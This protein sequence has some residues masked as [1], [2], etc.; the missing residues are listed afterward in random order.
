MPM[1]ML[2][3]LL[4]GGT[5]IPPV[6][7]P[8]AFPDY[9]VL[10]SNLAVAGQPSA[11]SVGRLKKM[12]FRTVVDL[13]SDERGANEEYAALKSQGLQ[14]AWVPVRAELLHA[15]D[16]LAVGQIISNRERGPFLVH[17]STVDHVGAVWAILAGKAG[18]SPEEALEEGRKAGL[19]SAELLDAV[20]G[21]FDDVRPE[22]LT[23]L[24]C[25]DENPRM[26][27]N[28]RPEY[29][30]AAFE[31]KVE[32][33][34]ELE[35]LI[36]ATGRVVQTDVKKSIPQLDQAAIHCV[37]KWQFSPARRK[38]RPVAVNASAPIVFRIPDK[39]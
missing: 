37:S 2:F 21:I 39:R 20:R 13:R 36:D 1:V 14:Y 5:E 19:A 38:G 6:M 31:E 27:R 15:H 32:G 10:R 34:V 7:D 33:T 18:R 25:A 35:I 22:P 3:A 24:D 16:A 11:E 29:P 23:C 30:V 8:A 12:G 28:V 17:G 26:I 9:R 4:L